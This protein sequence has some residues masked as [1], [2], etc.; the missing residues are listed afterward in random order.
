MSGA[1]AYAVL[2]SPRTSGT[3][4]MVI[5]ASW[6]SRDRESDGAKLNLRGVS[7]VL[8][9]ANF[10]KSEFPSLREGWR[11]FMEIRRVL[12]LGKGS[13]VHNQRWLPRG[14]ACLSLLIPRVVATK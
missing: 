9:L 3:E 1:N 13:G 2:S 14:H 11:Q 7:T 6:L 10:S 4:A 8:A 12:S 5:S